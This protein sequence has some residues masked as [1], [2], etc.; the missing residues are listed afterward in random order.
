MPR[1]SS[2][3]FYALLAGAAFLGALL[4]LDLLL[5][6]ADVLVRLGLVGKLYYLVLVPLGLAV[7][8]FLFGILKSYAKYKG[9]VL[10]GALE[11]GGP[12]VGFVLVLILGFWLDPEKPTFALTLFLHQANGSSEPFRRGTVLLRLGGD[13]RR[14]LVS[15]QGQA[16]FSGIPG[17]FRGQVVGVQLLDAPGYEAAQDRLTLDQ[18]GLDLE[19]RARPV[20]FRGYVK[21]QAGVPIP[22]ARVSLAEHETTTDRN[23]Y[24][25]LSVPD[26]GPDQP[27]T[28]QVAATGYGPWSSQ[29]TPGG[30][31]VQALLQATQGAETPP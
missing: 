6:R 9:Q 21:T 7:A 13:P 20:A 31:E 26:M 29:V 22:G 27:A 28:L 23:G 24:F 2:G 17:N 10:G 4:I 8:A 16:F 3:L 12:V 19:V 11:L 5:S 1:V 15:D 18:E 30:N 14:A 25:S